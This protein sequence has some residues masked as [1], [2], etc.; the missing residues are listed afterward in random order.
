[1]SCRQI[2]MFL[3]TEFIEKVISWIPS[4]HFIQL[5]SAKQKA[6]R[7]SE[8]ANYAARQMPFR[9]QP[10]LQHSFFTVEMR[11]VNHNFQYD[12]VL[13]PQIMIWCLT[14]RL[15]VS[16]AHR[17]TMTWMMENLHKHSSMSQYCILININITKSNVVIS[18]LNQ[19]KRQAV[20]HFAQSFAEYFFIWVDA[21]GLLSWLLSWCFVVTDDPANMLALNKY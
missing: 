21:V 15:P 18:E 6:S 3:G 11:G 12:I 2:L 16:K 10:G 20:L 19:T 17:I 4:F 5:C 8:E 9:A 13:I 1:M 7:K 14:V